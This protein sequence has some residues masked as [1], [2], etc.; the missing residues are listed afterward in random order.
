M[1]LDRVDDDPRYLSYCT[2]VH[3]GET[4]D[5]ITADLQRHAVPLKRRLRPDGPFALGLRLSERAI[6]ELDSDPGAFERFATFLN[7]HG[8]VAYTLNVFP[9]GGFHDDV[10]KER[11]YAPDWTEDSRHA[12]TLAAARV[13]ERLLPPDESF[14]TLSTLPLGYAADKSAFPREAATRAMARLAEDLARLE[15]TTGRRLLV[16]LEPEPLCVLETTRET[17]GWY[18]DELLAYAGDLTP[19]AARSGEELVRRHVGVCYDACHL[20][21]EFEDAAYS[22]ERY[23]REG[24][25]VGKIQI[26]CALEVQRPREN[27]DG[28][29]QL[30]AFAEPR[31]LHQVVA[32]D[33]SG[34]LHRFLDLPPFLQW[35]EDSDVRVDCA[36]CH[37]HVPIHLATSFPLG[38]TQPQLDE[39][40]HRE[41]RRRSVRHLEVETYTFD[42]LPAEAGASRHLSE[43]LEAELRYAQHGL[44]HD[45]G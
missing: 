17:I 6:T 8:F 24:I 37:F 30:A 41:L 43:S 12:Y 3:P 19:V 42:V 40:L 2:N 15:E 34:H 33:A 18:H 39:L 20:A 23:L 5:E 13:L 38:T 25:E 22:M 26:S 1:I 32:R 7:T 10:V 11:V 21:V 45:A 35:L 27:P 16:C 29:R 28:V 9:Q 44:T 14:G 4:L 36:R 31:F